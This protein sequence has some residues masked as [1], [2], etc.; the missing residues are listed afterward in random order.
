MR[1]ETAFRPEREELR[2]QVPGFQRGETQPRHIRLPQDDL[3]QI[4]E[5][6][7]KILSPGAEVDTGQHDLPGTAVQRRLDIEQNIRRRAAASFP[8]GN[9]GDTKSTVIVTAI[10]DLDEGACAVVQAR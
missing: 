1:H 2:I 9:G 3:D 6:L 10:L 8:A 7:S 4:L 5:V